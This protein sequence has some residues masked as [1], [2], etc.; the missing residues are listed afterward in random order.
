MLPHSSPLR[1][2]HD[3]MK[4]SSC[5]AKP[6]AARVPTLATMDPSAHG[7]ATMSMPKETSEMT[8]MITFSLPLAGILAIDSYIVE[9][10]N[11]GRGLRHT[12][13]ALFDAAYDGR[14][15]RRSVT[16]PLTEA[17]VILNHYVRSLPK[18][19]RSTPLLGRAHETSEPDL[20]HA[21]GD[22]SVALYSLPTCFC[23][24]S[25]LDS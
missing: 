13:S 18:D 3:G 8:A 11:G 16:I 14:G 17:S 22:L 25:E 21:M 7:D 1:Y 6:E 20:Y 19:G 12:Q 24:Q 15:P 9:N 10:L 5:R 2:S 23:C 4:P